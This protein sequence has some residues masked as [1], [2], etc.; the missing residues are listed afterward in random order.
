MVEIKNHLENDIFTIFVIGEVDA[1]S[2]IYLDESISEATKKHKKIMVNCQ[3]LEYIS[4][5]GLGVFMSYINDLEDKGIA[6]VIYGLSDKVKHVFQIL[7]LD[8]LLKITVSEDEAKR[9]VNGIQ[10]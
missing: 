9:M 5:A 3:Q 2:S 4:S 7:G 1:S 6:L 8:Q 10:V